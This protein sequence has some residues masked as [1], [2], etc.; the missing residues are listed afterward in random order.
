MSR[1]WRAPESQPPRTAT[2]PKPGPAAAPVPPPVPEAALPA[3]LPPPA[4]T[5][6]PGPPPGPPARAPAAAAAGEGQPTA[7]KPPL[8]TR[9][10]VVETR[11]ISWFGQIT[12]I[13]A[14]DVIGLS[15]YGADGIA[16]IV[17][18]GVKLDPIG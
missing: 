12:T 6:P 4:A 8:A 1:K 16:R 7:P 2:E 17:E 14:G 11:K 3:D 10:R 15:G 5:T 18:Q 13:N 9:W